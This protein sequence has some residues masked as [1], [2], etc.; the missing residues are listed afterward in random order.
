[1]QQDVRKYSIL[2]VEDDDDVAK[3]MDL[4]LRSQGYS[5]RRAAN[6]QEALS[7]L[8][9][10]IPSL[11]LLDMKMPVMNGWEFSRRF[12]QIYDHVVPVVVI[13]AAEDTQARAEEIGAEGWIQKPVELRSLF[14]KVRD[15]LSASRSP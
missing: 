2:V 7:L 1:M 8:E 13:S 9:A 3:L 12:R 6:G 15:Y 4:A 11:I 10:A 5:V 14:A